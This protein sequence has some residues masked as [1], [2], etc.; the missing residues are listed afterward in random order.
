MLGRWAEQALRCCPPAA[1][2]REG[3]ALDGKTL[4]GSK[5]QG[6][7][8]AHLLSAF[9]HRRGVVLGQ[10]GVPDKPNE[11]GAAEEF[12]LSIV[13]EG[14]GVTAD[15]LLTQRE[16]AQTSLASGGDSLLVVKENQPTRYADVAATFA[17]AA[18]DTGL[19]GT[20]C[21]VSQHGARSACRRL[22]A[23][24][25][26]VGS[27]AWPGRHQARQI[28]RRTIHKGTGV[29][30]RAETAYAVT[31]ARPRRA[32][33]PRLLA[34]WRGHWS[35]EHQWPSI[36]DVLF[37]ADRATVRAK[38]APQVMAACRSAA[39]GVIRRLGTTKS[40]ATCRQ[41]MAHPRAAFL[42]LGALPDL[43]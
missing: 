18:D 33:P 9:S 3:V 22:T 6:A 20:A 41:F 35:V 25:A 31:A 38:H 43:A 21:E 14:R 1:G 40:T 17:P 23:S 13:L 19:V 10:T 34:L 16:L 24:T 5:R 4:R 12:L 29:V 8:D 37:D 28:E 39:I 42:A 36:R 15:A 26:L 27:S 11:L 32:T 2:E 7:A 30:R